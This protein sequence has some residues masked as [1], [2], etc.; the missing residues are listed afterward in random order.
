MF[1]P[2]LQDELATAA[3]AAESLQF[4]RVAVSSNPVGVTTG[5][6]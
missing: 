3:A 2:L 4:A 5:V 1:S 6:K